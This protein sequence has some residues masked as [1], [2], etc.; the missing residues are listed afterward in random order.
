MSDDLLQL[1][2]PDN[3]GSDVLQRYRYQAHIAFP[4]CLHCCTGKKI[5]SIFVEHFEDVLIQYA[6][7]WHMMQIKTRNPDRGPWK[8]SD[9]IG[10]SGGIRGLSR[11]YKVAK[12]FNVSYGLYLEGA[13]SKDDKLNKL[14]LP[15][16]DISSEI[17]QEIVEKLDLTLEESKDFLE[18]LIVFPNQPHRDSIAATNLQ[19]LGRVASQMSLG[20]LEAVYENS[21]DEIFRAMEGEPLGERIYEVLALGDNDDAI[22]SPEIQAKRLTKKR[23]L[24]ILGSVVKGSY[25]LLERITDINKGNPTNLEVKLIAGG[26]DEN[27]VNDAKTL[28]AN[29]SIRIA[30]I[31][32]LSLFGEEKQIEDV[33]L[34]LVTLSDSVIQKHVDEKTPAR[35]AWDEVLQRLEGNPGYVD[36]NQIFRQDPYLLLGFVCELTDDCRITWGVPIA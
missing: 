18:N 11:T 24:G 23:L 32:S 25:P 13:I 4:F 12:G 9:V 19:I 15:D 26:A 7:S 20:E 2:P 17:V 8:F 29:A 10:K 33:G 1:T 34:R 35:K 22:I 36:P 3:T 5:V 6:D 28:R 27:V 31:S 16:K 30:Q 21:V 14:V